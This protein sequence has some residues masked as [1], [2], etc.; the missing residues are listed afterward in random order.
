MLQTN[1]NQVGLEFQ[2][3]KKAIDS[4]PLLDILELIKPLLNDLPPP[5]WYITTNAAGKSWIRN[6]DDIIID[7]GHNYD[8]ALPEF[9]AVCGTLAPVM[10]DALQALLNG[11]PNA[12]EAAYS[13][14]YAA[15]YEQGKIDAE[16]PI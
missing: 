16:L 8:V 12:I 2:T 11:E 1:I 14:G 6:Q 15:G 3:F 7:L 10:V 5:P 4:R 9:F 13:I